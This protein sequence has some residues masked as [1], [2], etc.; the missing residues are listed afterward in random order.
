MHYTDTGYRSNTGYQ[1]HGNLLNQRDRRRIIRILLWQ[2][3]LS[4]LSESLELIS[5]WLEDKNFSF[6]AANVEPTG[7][8]SYLRITYD[9]PVGDHLGTLDLY[10]GFE[11]DR[12]RY[13]YI[14]PDRN[15][16]GLSEQGRGPLGSI[17][18]PKFFTILEEFLESFLEK[19]T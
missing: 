13:W 10:R 11:P 2:A 5:H 8:R 19:H 7:L 15:N 4:N 6:H 16:T 1:P 12:I 14:L 3:L 18:D 17:A 9:C